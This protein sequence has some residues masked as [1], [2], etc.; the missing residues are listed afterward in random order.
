V[1]DR[2]QD[3]RAFAALLRGVPAAVN[4]IPWN[5]VDGLPLAAPAPDR[6]RAFAALLTRL[7]VTATVRRPRGQDVGVACGQLRRRAKPAP[8]SA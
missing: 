7:G 4:L 8:T 3:A 2:D 5:A 6:V 1:N